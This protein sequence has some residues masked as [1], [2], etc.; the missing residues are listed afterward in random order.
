MNPN[1]AES[2]FEYDFW[3]NSR[4]FEAIE[5]FGENVPHEILELMSHIHGAKQVWY[6][7]IQNIPAGKDLFEVQTLEMLK[8]SNESLLQLW[9]DLIH[10]IDI[11]KTQ[12]TYNNLAGDSFESSISDI[13]TQLFSHGSYHRGQVARII[14]ESGQKPL[15]T[16]F[17]VFA[18]Q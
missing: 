9:S 18:R 14:R 8:R 1:Y 2:L 17:I 13:I 6:N 15:S 10:R 5:P 12:I 4:V 3:A 7:R 11:N 16:D